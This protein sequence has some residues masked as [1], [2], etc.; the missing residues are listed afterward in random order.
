MC[1]APDAA[2][3]SG[4][5]Y[6]VLSYLCLVTKF[7]G[8]ITSKDRGLCGRDLC[9]LF[10]WLCGVRLWLGVCFDACVVIMVAQRWH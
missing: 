1:V 3:S 8:Y 9:M 2:M 7:F 4:R 6:R 10:I 5:W